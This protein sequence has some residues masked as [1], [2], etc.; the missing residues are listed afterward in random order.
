MYK[1]WTEEDEFYLKQNWNKK[2]TQEIADNLGR[3]YDSV[4]TKAKTLG[5]GPNKKE[6]SRNW[7]EEELEY[8]MDSW[9]VISIE[10]IA[11]KL[12]RTTHAVSLKAGRL[13]LGPFLE[14]GE[15]L[16]LNRLLNEIFGTYVGKQYTIK[17]WIELP[18]AQ[19]L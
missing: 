2:R 5:L 4:Y 6:S 19:V 1:R 13:G 8:L 11:K 17:S 10:S 12:N 16:T 7:T 14:S 3:T 18:G 9:G 15:Y